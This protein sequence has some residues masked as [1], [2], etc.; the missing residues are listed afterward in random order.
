MSRKAEGCAVG[1]FKRILI[2]DYAVT[3]ES[4]GRIV[5]VAHSLSILTG[6]TLRQSDEKVGRFRLGHD[7]L[8]YENAGAIVEAWWE[9][10]R[11]SREFQSSNYL[12]DKRGAFSKVLNADVR[13]TDHIGEFRSRD[14]VSALDFADPQ[15]W[16]HGRLG[17][18][19]RVTRSIRGHFGGGRSLASLAKRILS[20][21]RLTPSSLEKTQR[22]ERIDPSN[23][24]DSPIRNRG[25]LI[26]FLLGWLCFGGGCGL[27]YFY[28]GRFDDDCRRLRAVYGLIFSGIL[29]MGGLVLMFFVASACGA[30]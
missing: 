1:F 14:V 11:L 26:P 20:E 22:N 7:R 15:V 9:W 25:T 6:N 28:W 2:S 3:T 16:S 30:A 4:F 8:Q 10:Q 13:I 21:P 19:N 27:N 29:V 5:G 24:Q 23:N 18:L 12:N 17:Y